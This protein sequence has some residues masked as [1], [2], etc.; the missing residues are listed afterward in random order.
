MSCW[1]DTF[2]ASLAAKHTFSSASSTFSRYYNL[3]YGHATISDVDTSPPFL[4]GDKSKLSPKTAQVPKIVRAS[5]AFVWDALCRLWSAT[6]NP[7]RW[8]TRDEWKRWIS[9]NL[10]FPPESIFYLSFTNLEYDKL[11]KRY[12]SKGTRILFNSYVHTYEKCRNLRH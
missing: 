10:N 11:Y 12:L 6:S 7:M 8:V 9:I 4:F 2:R 5:S 1:S 3:P